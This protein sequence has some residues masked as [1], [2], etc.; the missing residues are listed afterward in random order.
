MGNT[1]RGILGICK[2]NCGKTSNFEK[3]VSKFADEGVEEDKGVFFKGNRDR[4]S[5]AGIR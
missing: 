5:D 4:E 2:G 1:K 3:I